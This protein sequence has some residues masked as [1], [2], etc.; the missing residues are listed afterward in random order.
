MTTTMLA[1][2]LLHEARLV[3]GLV[4][5]R[6]TPGAFTAEVVEILR[7]FATQSALAI[8]NARLNDLR[9]IADEIQDGTE[10]HLS[11]AYVVLKDSPIRTIEDLKGK[12]VAIRGS[13]GKTTT[14]TLGGELLASS[15]QSALVGRNIGTPSSP[16]PTAG[17]TWR[18]IF[19]P[20]VVDL[21]D[22]DPPSP[23]AAVTTVMNW[24]SYDP[25][26][27]DGQV[28]GHK[29]VEFEKFFDLITDLAASGQLDPARM[30]TLA[31]EYGAELDLSSAPRLVAAHGLTFPGA[32]QPR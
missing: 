18:P 10:G 13:N 14:T 31:L 27:F 21:F 26:E 9:I 2:P 24:Q 3:G 29:D 22:A 4:V 1:I 30:E 28:Y 8:Q 17:K 5:T 20:V 19:H 7:T 15:S 12:I 32:P 11:L 16:A 6:R 25:L 23:A